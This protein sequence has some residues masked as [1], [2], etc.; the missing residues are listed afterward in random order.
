MGR[1]LGAGHQKQKQHRHQFVMADASALFFDLHELRD[2]P[3]AALLARNLQARL[4]I[5]AHLF[6]GSKQVKESK[7]AGKLR[8]HIG[9]T[10]ERRPV[11]ERQAEKLANH[12]QRQDAR[13]S[14]NEIGGCSLRKQ[15]ACKLIGNGR[16]VGLHLK[17][18]AASKRLIHDPAQSGVVRI[19]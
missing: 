19:V 14:R 16:D 5:A 11:G 2:Q 3:F 12:R 17:H 15:L 8:R 6:H 18:G 9:P 1:S 7:R 10:D 4:H 13:V